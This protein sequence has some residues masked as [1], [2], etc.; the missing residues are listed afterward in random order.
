MADAETLF[1]E[2]QPAVLRYLTRI[3]GHTETARDLAQDVFLRISRSTVPDG[4]GAALRAWVFRIARNLA[5]NHLRDCARRPLA[6]E[7]VDTASPAAAETTI[8][9][10]QALQR[11]ADVD[12]DVFLLR[13]IGG[14][15]YD[16]L[17][18][19]CELTPDA[20]RSRLHRARAELRG[21][22]TGALQGQRRGT[23]RLWNKS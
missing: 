17:A 20:V 2:H 11:L 7:V 5:F 15:S 4:D 21:L 6:V 3:V 9:V 19:V 8:A 1:A 16:E 18:S 13:E 23:I 10:R 14:L 12:R 22:L